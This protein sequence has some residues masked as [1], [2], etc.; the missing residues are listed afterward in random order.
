MSRQSG[1]GKQISFVMVFI[2]TRGYQRDKEDYTGS[3]AKATGYVR[4]V[5]IGRPGPSRNTLPMQNNNFK[6][7]IIVI[8]D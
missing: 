1:G 2:Q 4:R 5:F 7:T 8:T 6:R 3:Q